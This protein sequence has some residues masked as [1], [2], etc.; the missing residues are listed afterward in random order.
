MIGFPRYLAHRSLS[1]GR[2]REANPGKIETNYCM[3]DG[4]GYANAALLRQLQQVSWLSSEE[5][6]AELYAIS[7][8]I[9]LFFRLPYSFVSRAIRYVL[10]QRAINEA[11]EISK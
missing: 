3:T 8:L 6:R 1:D 7:N 11:D 2:T 5:N 10:L 9:G 4:C